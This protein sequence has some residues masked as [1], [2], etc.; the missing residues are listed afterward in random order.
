[1]G[2][3]GVELSNAGDDL[4]LR[5]TERRVGRGVA[6][7]CF[8]FVLL[9]A[10]GLLGWAQHSGARANGTVPIL[11]ALALAVL[12][13]WLFLRGLNS[14]V[15]RVDI[16]LDRDTVTCAYRSLRGTKTWREPHDAYRGL[17]ARTAPRAGG[18]GGVCY[19]I[20][21]KHLRDAARDVV[22]HRARSPAGRRARIVRIAR[23]LGAPVLVATS[24]GSEARDAGAATS[25]VALAAEGKL[26][27]PLAPA[28]PLVV[29]PLR[30]LPRADGY[31]FER[32]FGGIAALYGAIGILIGVAALAAYREI[33]LAQASAQLRV[34]LFAGMPCLALGIAGIVFGS[35]LV[36]TLEVDATGVRARLVFAGRVQRETVLAVDAV[37][38]VRAEPGQGVHIISDEG[39]IE[40]ARGVRARAIR[41]VADAV[42]AT[43]ARG[44]SSP[45]QVERL[46]KFA[47]AAFA[48]GLAP[49]QVHAKLS[50]LGAPAEDVY[51]CLRAIADDRTSPHAGLMRAYF[52]L[53]PVA[54]AASSAASP[55]LALPPIVAPGAKRS[56]RAPPV[57]EGAGTGAGGGFTTIAAVAVAL[58][59]LAW[60][61]TPFLPRG[62]A[63]LGPWL[64]KP[65]FAWLHDATRPAGGADYATAV[66]IARGFS[67]VEVLPAPDARFVLIGAQRVRSAAQGA[68]LRV[69]LEQLRLEKRADQ[70]SVQYR[71]LGIAVAPLDA[72]R[73][74]DWV[75]AYDLNVA[76]TLTAE[77]PVA[78]F[79]AQILVVPAMAQA[80]RG[81]CQARLLLQVRVGPKK[82]YNETSSAFTLAPDGAAPR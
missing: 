75:P 23:Q 74:T 25:V 14:I 12:G 47:L 52:K 17:L 11:I 4:P 71:A 1:M 26:R 42:L 56:L 3:S 65:V 54:A 8:G 82:I 41:I 64:P 72:T 62:V 15:T 45:G 66:R 6:L 13:L 51:D 29:A 78:T 58:V 9:G 2:R 28:A 10:A 43:L 22:L 61:A 34:A 55:A 21:L 20:V 33:D 76:G 77:T 67:G 81:G 19:L 53:A 73:R 38:E 24:A 27:V 57:G 48:A 60:F 46:R 40:F 39:A 49:D 35:K 16:T 44:A 31:A 80:C 7:A 36:S 69:A 79:D 32:G 63:V 50:S 5:V 37:D 70:A 30:A 68:Q 18:R 59:L